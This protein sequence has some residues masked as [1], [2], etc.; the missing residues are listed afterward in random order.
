MGFTAAVPARFSGCHHR[1]NP[2]EMIKYA[3]VSGDQITFISRIAAL[4]RKV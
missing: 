4:C 1:R 3:S 2:P